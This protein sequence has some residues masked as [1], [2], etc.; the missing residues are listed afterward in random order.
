[1]DSGDIIAQESLPIPEDADAGAL[2]D[3]L[4]TRGARLLVSS[5]DAIR[6]GTV[7][8]TPQDHETA[9]YCGKITKTDG[10]IDWSVMPARQI[11]RMVRA[12]TPWPGVRC[13]WGNTTIQITRAT[14]LGADPS[15]A[16]EPPGTVLGIDTGS[17]ILIQTT[18][19]RLALRR[20]KPQA[21]SEMDS[22]SFVN[23]NPSIIGSVLE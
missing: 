17:G 22:R 14:A 1:M 20:I 18:D 11:E 23:G 2:H 10:V 3:V 19:G 7:A 13:R 6:T 9:T 4:A 5:L 21:R 8:A 16:D 15:S 12:Y